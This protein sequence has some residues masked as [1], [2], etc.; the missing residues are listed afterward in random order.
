MMTDFGVL[1]HDGTTYWGKPR[2]IP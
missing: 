2:K 1:D